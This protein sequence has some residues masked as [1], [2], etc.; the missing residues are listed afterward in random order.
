M[1]SLLGPFRERVGDRAL[2]DLPPEERLFFGGTGHLTP[3]GNALAATLLA[4]FLEG[5][6]L[7]R[8][9]APSS[10]GEDPR[11]PAA[12]LPARRPASVP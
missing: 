8:P 12:L 11:P 5:S 3:A 9:T 7:P 6:V 10:P 4:E 1:L 2:S